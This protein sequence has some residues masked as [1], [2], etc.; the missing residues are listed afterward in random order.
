[1]W[2]IMGSFPDCV[3]KMHL[4]L[5]Q[6][7]T[8]LLCFDY[9]HMF[10]RFLFAIP[11]KK[12]EHYSY[13]IQRT[14]RVNQKWKTNMLLCGKMKLYC[15]Y[16]VW[17]IPIWSTVYLTLNIVLKLEQNLFV[18]YLN[19]VQRSMFHRWNTMLTIWSSM[20]NVLPFWLNIIAC[21]SSPHT[22]WYRSSVAV[23]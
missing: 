9:S 12:V 19:W 22:D 16:G 14:A 18:L 11:V 10:L 23:K 13:L 6:C 8:S 20:K 5:L 7:N 15:L 21:A 17:G 3:F 2:K 1:M 4:S